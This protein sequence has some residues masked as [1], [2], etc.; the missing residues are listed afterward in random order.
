MYKFSRF[1]SPT[2]TMTLSRNAFFLSLLIIFASPFVI[3]KLTWLSRTTVTHGQVWFMGKTIE[4]DGSI[5][6]HLV[7]LFL[8]GK[9]SISFNAPWNLPFAIG[10]KVS[11]RYVSNNPSDARVNTFLRVWGDTIVYGIWP[12]L[13]LLVIY[14][15]PPKLDPLVPWGSKVRVGGKGV[16]R[17]IPRSEPL[18]FAP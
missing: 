16:I 11:V 13:V 14:L 17:I 6:S 18:A 2:A 10:E 5:S 7:I 12:V 3:W 9:D 1:I 8:A 4:L 15:I